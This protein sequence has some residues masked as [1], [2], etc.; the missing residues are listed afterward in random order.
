MDTSLSLIGFCATVRNVLDRQ[1]FG[2]N[3]SE[4]DQ[5][6]WDFFNLVELKLCSVRRLLKT[7]CSRR[8]MLQ[9]MGLWR[10]FS[11]GG[12]LNVEVIGMLVGNFFGKP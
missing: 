2:L 1:R 12:T 7:V 8:Q 11:P 4:S 10:P 3:F 6:F 9:E 5:N